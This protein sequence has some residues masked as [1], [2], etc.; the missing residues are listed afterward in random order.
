MR[1]GFLR[2]DKRPG[3][4]ARGLFAFTSLLKVDYFYF[5]PDRVD[6]EN[7]IIRGLFFKNGKLVERETPYP[8]IVDDIYYFRYQS[9]ALFRE[10]SAYCAFV[11]TPLMGKAKVYELLRS[12]ENTA[13]YLIET[14]KYSDCDIDDIL[15]KHKSV[16]LKPDMG[17]HG[18][19]LYKLHKEKDNYILQKETELLKIAPEDYRAQYVPLFTKNYVLQPYIRSRTN[20]DIPFHIRIHI[21]RGRRGE[22]GTRKI[23]PRI[24]KMGALASNLERGGGSTAEIGDFLPYELG[25]GWKKTYDK[26][27]EISEIIPEVIQSGYN[28][29]VDALGIDIGINREVDNEPKIFE[30]NAFPE[31]KGF[32][33]EAC[34]AMARYY[35]F[36]IK[37]QTEK[38]KINQE[39]GQWKEDIS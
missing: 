21:R 36:L 32:E 17:N 1:I 25:A 13:A 28:T 16:I 26:L 30:V 39:E 5:T 27:V 29:L 11:F 31:V 14:L 20:F 22:W 33:L 19:N 8:D 3:R 9:P 10:L 35:R 24:G 15:L 12:N 37:T 2:Y 38:A 7:K 18:D 6:V 34:E 23:Y 4:I